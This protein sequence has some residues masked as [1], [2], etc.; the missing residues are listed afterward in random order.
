[1]VS[2]FVY[3]FLFSV[4]RR[5]VWSLISLLWCCYVYWVDFNMI[6]E[7]ENHLVDNFL[8]SPKSFFKTVTG[9]RINRYC[10]LKEFDSGYGVADIVVSSLVPYLST[11][12]LRK[13]VDLNWVSTLIKQFE[14]SDF[15]IAE[16]SAFCGVSQKTVKEKII[17]CAEAGL[18]QEKNKVYSKANDYRIIIDVSIAIEAKLKNWKQALDQARRY[19]RFATY[20][21]VLLDQRHI[22]AA[23][24]NIK[25]FKLHE[26]GLVTMDGLRPFVHY[27]PP[28]KQ[29]SL[30][31][32]F[33]KLNEAMYGCFKAKYGAYAKPYSS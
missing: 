16:F 32:Y 5:T 18:L 1:M 19:K 22:G 2:F 31:E 21:F 7:S 3:L 8:C 14:N 6:Y 11:R 29:V 33:Y 28:S 24:K 23:L 15:T 9:D 26:I 4:W 12:Y 17:Q 27:N 20:S 10:I 30:N 13:S 25:A